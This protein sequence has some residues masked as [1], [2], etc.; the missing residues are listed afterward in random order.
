MLDKLVKILEQNNVFLSG[1]AGVGKSFLTNEL[2]RFYKN[3]GKSVVALGSSALSAFNVGGV[4][5]H[6]F[7]CLG[8]CEDAMELSVYDRKQREKLSKLNKILKKLDLIIIDEISMVS[9]AIFDMIALRLKSSSFDGKILLV[10]DFFQLPP[11]VKEKQN[12]LFVTSVY[13][14]SSL[15][16]QELNLVNLRLCISKRTQNMQFYEY[17]SFLRQGRIDEKILEYFKQFLINLEELNALEDEFTLLCGINKKA[18]FINEQKLSKLPNEL[19]V[20]QANYK[21]EDESLDDT[22]FRAWVKGLNI[23][24]ELRIKIGARV[25]FCLN[26]YEQNYCN[27]EQGIVSAIIEDETKTYMQITKNNGVQILLEPYTFLLEELEQDDKELFINIRASVKQ[28]PIKLAYAITIHK[29]QGMSIDKL[30][31]DIDNIFE[32]GQ[33]YVALSRAIN[34]DN[35]HIFYSKN[36]EFKNYFSKIL[37]FDTSVLTFYEENQFLDL[38]ENLN[39]E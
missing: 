23:C 19:F 13:A 31:C 7:F 18:D 39:K 2:I 20:Y 32:N 11:V 6:S 35:L 5:L 12:S 3:K 22:Q 30:V 28:F 38:E 17:L 1:G 14:F 15:F 37:K 29:S 36:I 9:A 33:L 26:N 34:P 27:G 24:E 21:K 10:G 25:I 16:W 8:R 4:T